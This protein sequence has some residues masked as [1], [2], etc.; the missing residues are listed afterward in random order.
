MTNAPQ[1]KLA[2][3]EARGLVAPASMC[4]PPT[5]MRCTTNCT[6][7]GCTIETAQLGCTIETAPAD[8]DYGMR[9]MSVRDPD[10]DRISFGQEV[11]Q[12][13]RNA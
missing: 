5:S 2:S 11:K 6:A 9:E 8:Y 4:S 10:G 13:Q 12:S 1:R 7:L 3:Q